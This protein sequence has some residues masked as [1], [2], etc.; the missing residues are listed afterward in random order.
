[1]KLQP[2]KGFNK[3]NRI[4]ERIN[5]ECYFRLQDSKINYG[6]EKFSL[7]VTVDF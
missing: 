3:E 1:M 7:N 2:S 5:K 6:I 4:K